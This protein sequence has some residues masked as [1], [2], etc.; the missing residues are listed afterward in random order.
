MLKKL[1]LTLLVLTLTACIVECQTKP[2]QITVYNGGYALVKDTRS[3]DFIKGIS[4][5][6]VMDV[7]AQIDAT[8][9]LFKPLTNSNSITILEQNYQFDLIN[10]ENILSK[11]VGQR[12]WLADGRSGILMNP[13]ANGGLVVK[14]DDGKLQFTSIG[15]LHT[16]SAVLK[17]SK[18]SGYFKSGDVR[19][20]IE[21]LFKGTGR[22]FSIES[23]VEGI[24]TM[25]NSDT[26]D[27]DS[28]LR[29]ICKSAALVYRIENGIYNISR[30]IPASIPTTN[31]VVNKPTISGIIST[32]N[33]PLGLRARP[34]LN[35]LVSSDVAGKQNCE[36]SYLTNGIG[37]KADYVA[38]V[39]KNDSALDLSGWVTINNKS[40][41]T[42]KEAQLTLMAGDVR[43][44]QP[45][46]QVMY[47]AS[48]TLAN[49][50]SGFEEK[51]F[52][53]YHIYKLQRP[54]TIADK[55]TKQ[56][57]LLSA[58]GSKVQKIY[59]YDA[60]GDWF[61]GWWYP[62]FRGYPGGS[63]DT[64]NYHKV[65]VKLELKNSKDN[66]MGM[67]LP[68]GTIR[69]YKLDDDG[70][71]QFVGED[72]IDH[73]PKDEKISLYLGDAFDIVGDYK[74]TDH[75]TY[76]KVYED[77]FEIKIR[78]HK[79]EAVTVNVMDHVWGDWE[80]TRK[81]HVFEKRD[82]STIVFPV[83]VAPDKEVVI[84]YSVRIK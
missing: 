7:A 38:L 71:Q 34:T 54:A 48:R 33:L 50:V 17:E 58:T 1:S 82:A 72:E 75:K 19:S 13:P 39:N 74:R 22:N 68:K 55:E 29:E 53:E 6:D 77:S 41:A 46:P 84:E 32:D 31:Q 79:S 24:A 83:T 57:S 65:N 23:D 4:S 61:R 49:S 11:I 59:T 8:S 43:R 42:Y 16:T 52:F 80:I 67:P 37:W 78:N 28:R 3:I 12:V 47:K 45:T 10:P 35:W 60:R 18:V 62:G 64:S 51:S 36:I 56:I 14:M 26:G 73:T 44:I 2:L 66:E 76:G 63:L 40:G 15:E 27:F 30:K 69:V 9:V 70:S 81:T 20:V 25:P 21:T 5:I